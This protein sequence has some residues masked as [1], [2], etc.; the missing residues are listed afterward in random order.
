VL[1]NELKMIIVLRSPPKGAQKR[2]TTVFRLAIR[3]KKVCYKV[4]LCDNC[5]RQCC[6]AFIDLTIRAKM[7]G[8]GRLLLLKIL[9]QTDRIGAKSPIFDL[10]SEP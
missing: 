8:G 3:L 6:E 7:I 9:G 4:F 10:H 2:K 1:S 5:Q